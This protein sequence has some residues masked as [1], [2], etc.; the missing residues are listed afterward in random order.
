MA[1]RNVHTT[2]PSM[3][4]CRPF[5]DKVVAGLGG[6]WIVEESPHWQPP[7]PIRFWVDLRIRHL[8]ARLKF[9]YDAV[10]F[11]SDLLEYFVTKVPIDCGMSASD[12]PLPSAS[13]K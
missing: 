3:D 5:L 2:A 10:L 13:G 7:G 9:Q 12:C 1:P 11:D 8:Q 6:D 4:E